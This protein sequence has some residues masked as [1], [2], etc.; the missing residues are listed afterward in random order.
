MMDRP[1][2]GREGGEGEGVG[3]KGKGGGHAYF[4]H[5]IIAGLVSR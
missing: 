3:Q 2:G 1:G 4:I 5:C